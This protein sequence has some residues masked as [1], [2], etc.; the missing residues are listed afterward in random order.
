MESRTS[1]GWEVIVEG[2]TEEQAR[3]LAERVKCALVLE[4]PERYGPDQLVVAVKQ[5]ETT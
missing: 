5:K 3:Q 2:L 4:L 1:S